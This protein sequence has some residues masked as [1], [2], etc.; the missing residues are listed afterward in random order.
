MQSGTRSHPKFSKLPQGNNVIKIGDSPAASGLLA[1]LLL[2]LAQL[3]LAKKAVGPGG[4]IGPKR[5][6]QFR[7]I[8]GV[9]SARLVYV[10]TSHQTTRILIARGRS[11]AGHWE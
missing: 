6:N 3:V 11:V 10:H 2:A 8:E 1:G 9:A 7:A 5:R 4:I